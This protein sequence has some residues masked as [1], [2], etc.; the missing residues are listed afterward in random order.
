MSPFRSLIAAALA[1]ALFPCCARSSPPEEMGGIA[2]PHGVWREIVPPDPIHR[3]GATLTYDSRRGRFVLFGGFDRGAHCND[4]WLYSPG[5]EPGWTRLEVEGPAPARRQLHVAVYDP[6]EDR[7]LVHGGARDIRGLFPQLRPAFSDTWELRFGPVPS[8]RLLETVGG[9]AVA[10]SAHGASLDPVRRELVVVGGYSG[11]RRLND[12]WALDLETGQWH[13]RLGLPPDVVPCFAGASAVDTARRRVYVAAGDPGA[14]SEFADN[15]VRV[16]PFSAD[17]PWSELGTAG[18]LPAR[19]GHSL[20][21]D[22]SRDR[23]VVFGGESPTRGAFVNDTWIMSLGG[24]PVWTRL[25]QGP[26]SLPAPRSGHSV[27]FVP[28][29]GAVL[30]GGAGTTTFNDVWALGTLPAPSWGRLTPSGTAPGPR[31]GHSAVWDPLRRR[32]IVFGG[33]RGQIMYSEV[34]ALTLSAQRSWSRLETIGAGPGVRSGHMAAYDPVHD[35]M[36]VYG[37]RGPDGALGDV[38]ALSLSGFPTWSRVPDEGEQPPA[39]WLHGGGYD[40]A[41][42][43]WLVVAGTGD[44]VNPRADAWWLSIGATVRAEALARDPV[45]PPRMYHSVVR[46]ARRNRLVAFGGADGRSALDDAWILDLGDDQGWQRVEADGE[47]PGARWGAVAAYDGAGDRM[48]IALGRSIGTQ[49]DDVWA[50]SLDGPPRWARQSPDG[51]RPTP[52]ERAAADM[53][54][55]RG[56][57]VVYGG[58]DGRS[59]DL[60]EVWTLRLGGAPRWDSLGAVPYCTPD[61]W[62]PNAV[63]DAANDRILLLKWPNGLFDPADA[64]VELW[65]RGLEDASAWH[66]I[67]VAGSPPAARYGAAAVLDARR[68]RLIVFGGAIGGSIAPTNDLWALELGGTPR[69]TALEALGEAP[70][71]RYEHLAVYDSQRDRMIVFGGYQNREDGFWELSLAD[72]PTWSRKLAAGPDY[73][74]RRGAASAL[75]AARERLVLVGGSSLEPDPRPE[76]L[77]LHLPSL[78]WDAREPLGTPEYP[79]FGGRAVYDATAQRVVVFGRGGGGEDLVGRPG[80]VTFQGRPQWS[81]LS[82]AGRA[83]SPRNVSFVFYD[84]RRSRVMLIG[85]ASGN[86][87]L[88]DLWVL[89]FAEPITL[90]AD[91]GPVPGRPAFALDAPGPNPA[92]GRLALSIS[93]EGAAPGRLEVFDVAGRRRWSEAWDAGHPG[94]RALDVDASGWAPGIYLVRLAEGTRIA[95]RRIALIR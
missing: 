13:Q 27:V 85:G 19:R 3:E 31:R 40:A 89:S 90:N 64:P 83:P 42:G 60:G 48:L 34:W 69:W 56:E 7:L 81:R 30:F 71:P 33:E 32:M 79:D 93:L 17:E 57:L 35:R 18:V 65:S 82:P 52:R 44:G 95:T 20:T 50:L 37:G 6:V 68:S 67:E 25:E 87:Y 9:E 62:V 46:D 41:T 72:P 86:D 80:T 4:V 70:G 24:E 10:R 23:L 76:M 63:L 14:A 75:D 49:Y 66:R 38:W 11:T 77:Q 47:R 43:R 1:L 21:L 88:R 61:T 45:M 29:Y 36:M 92:R 5:S 28:S 16:Y 84:E 94:R 51:A 55:A 59:V 78:H 15:Y 53:D 54:A 58:R 12:L 91:A 26:S 39:R 74:T 22:E 73:A 2:E 8:W